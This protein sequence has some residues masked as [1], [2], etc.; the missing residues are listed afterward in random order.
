MNI[1]TLRRPDGTYRQATARD[2]RR[3]LAAGHVTHIQT[4]RGTIAIRPGTQAIVR[5]HGDEFGPTREV[6]WTVDRAVAGITDREQSKWFPRQDA[7]RLVRACLLF[8]NGILHAYAA[9]D[10]V[11]VEAN[12]GT[13]D[14]Y[15]LAVRG[16]RVLV[17]YEMPAGTSALVFFE[18]IGEELHRLNTVPHRSLGAEWCESI[19]EQDA[20]HLWIGRGQRSAHPI[21]MPH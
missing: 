2:I 8:L 7:N 15:V 9:G 11:E 4:A 21:P 6:G 1:D 14:G 12:Q 16:N 13:R 19:R 18:A 5:R 3:M 10:S 17:E 20:A